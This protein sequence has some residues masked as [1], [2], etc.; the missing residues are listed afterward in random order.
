MKGDQI[1]VEYANSHC[2]DSS[3]SQENAED[4]FFMAW[5]I[6]NSSKNQKHAK[7]NYGGIEDD[8]SGA[9]SKIAYRIFRDAVVGI[10]CL[11]NEH[12]DQELRGPQ[13]RKQ[14]GDSLQMHI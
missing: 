4:H 2:T 12:E 11:S 1:F 10:E 9:H 5:V 7:N 3:Q 8:R 13:E 6:Y 14:S